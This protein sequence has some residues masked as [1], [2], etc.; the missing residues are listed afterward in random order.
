MYSISQRTL[1]GLFY[2]PT[3]FSNTLLDKLLDSQDHELV[4][5]AAESLCRID[6]DNSKAF[7]LL[8]YVIVNSECSQLPLRGIFDTLASTNEYSTEVKKYLVNLLETN[9]LRQEIVCEIAGVLASIDDKNTRSLGILNNLLLKSLNKLK[10]IYCDRKNMPTTE[11]VNVFS[12]FFYPDYSR[13]KYNDLLCLRLCEIL[14]QINKN[15]EGVMET[16]I[17]LVRHSDDYIVPIHAA[18]L[19]LKYDVENPDAI[20]RLV[21]EIAGLFHS[22]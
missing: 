18:S 6:P 3:D 17:F 7:M 9:D 12:R 19:L 5:I 8:T 14:N 11:K 1:S 20:E 13:N 10:N 15:R 4:Q 16:L 22:N 21:R 2:D